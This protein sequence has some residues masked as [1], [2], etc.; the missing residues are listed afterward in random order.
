MS[1]A[2]LERAKNT[3]LGP[4]YTIQ[5]AGLLNVNVRYLRHGSPVLED[6]IA[7]HGLLVVGALYDIESGVIDFFDG[8]P[9]TDR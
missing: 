8:D 3:A 2:L 7:N 4:A 9:T 1:V 5:A 6:L